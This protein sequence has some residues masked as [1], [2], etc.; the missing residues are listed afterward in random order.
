MGNYIIKDIENKKYKKFV[1]WLT[2]KNMFSYLVDLEEDLGN[3]SGFILIDQIV[4]TGKKDRF[5][6]LEILNGRFD[7]K[8]A[9][10][11]SSAFIKNINEL[12]KLTEDTLKDYNAKEVIL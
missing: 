4:I 11:V 5:L 7:L 8:S 9:N 6:E 12:K 10:I 3:I 1:I 2:D